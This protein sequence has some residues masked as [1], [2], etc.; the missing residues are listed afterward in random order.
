MFQFSKVQ[1]VKIGAV[2]SGKSKA[3]AQALRALDDALKYAAALADRIRQRI[4]RDGDTGGNLK[5][6]STKRRKVRVSRA[7][8]RSVGLPGNQVVWRSSRAWHDA[9]GI[10]D[11]TFA[12]TG[13]M[14][15]GMRVRNRGTGLAVTDFVGVSLGQSI[16]WKKPLKEIAAARR[17]ELERIAAMKDGRR[18]SQAREKLKGYFDRYMVDA[19]GVSANDKALAV[20]KRGIHPAKPKPTELDAISW[21]VQ[22][23]A[24]QVAVLHTIDSL[25]SANL[26]AVS[27]QVRGVRPFGDE[28][29]RRQLA[30]LF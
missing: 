10:R 17:Q 9:A 30:E 23:R 27:A 15:R 22:T 7:Y 8:Q 21:S 11:G 24:L 6:Y 26:A 19:N 28:P 2:K 16:R 18:K 4:S 3:D 25:T 20:L 13:G 1:S 14:W 12:G 29:L 5:P